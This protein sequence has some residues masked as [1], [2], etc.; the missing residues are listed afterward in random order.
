MGLQII[1]YDKEDHAQTTSWGLTLDQADSVFD[2]WGL[3]SNTTQQQR[4]VPL[5][6]IV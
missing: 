1:Q 5:R 2:K 4:R 6:S 3:S